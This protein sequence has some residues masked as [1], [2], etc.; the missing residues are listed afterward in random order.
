[1]SSP[2]TI[3]DL[4]RELQLSAATV[5]LAL[6]HHTRISHAT[7]KRVIR[8]ARDLGYTPDPRLGQ[9]M[10]Y[11]REDKDAAS[12]ETVAYVR[13]NGS[14]DEIY[15]ED[16]N[17]K[18]ALQRARELGYEL[19]LFSLEGLNLSHQ[20]LDRVLYTR[21]IRGVILA[22]FAG[23]KG[24]FSLKWERYAAVR[25]A[26]SVQWPPVH[27]I[28]GHHFNNAYIAIKK[29][30]SLGYRRIGMALPPN[31][32]ER[33]N[34]LWRAAFSD[35]NLMVAPRDQVKGF[36]EA[37]INRALRDWLKKEKPDAVITDFGSGIHRIMEGTG[38]LVPEDM[39]LAAIGRP[40]K[41]CAYSGVVN[42]RRQVGAIALEAVAAMLQQNEFGL[43]RYPK[44]TMI[45]GYW[46]NGATT[47]KQARSRSKSDR[48]VASILAETSQA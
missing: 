13:E 35:Y 43:P 11:L 19:E 48:R 25:L 45:N 32:N 3:R 10:R 27:R 14:P 20:A 23:P 8:K 16:P 28:S 12:K 17:F 40:G 2:P 46:A 36:F 37:P 38:F 47:H 31:S 34:H 22:P 21:G 24:R 33:T 41:D 9:L 42:N 44:T 39:G 29:L 1:M 18:G 5:S 7:R 26:Y 15:R 30:R 4:A 6:R